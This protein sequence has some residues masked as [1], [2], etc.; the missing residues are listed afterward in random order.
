MK[1]KQFW[2]MTIRKEWELGM[3]RL[4]K[5]KQFEA[6]TEDYLEIKQFGITTI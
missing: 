5:N 6:K 3:T 1:S 2:I 4:W